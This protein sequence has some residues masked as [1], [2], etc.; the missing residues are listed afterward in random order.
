MDPEKPRRS[1]VVEVDAPPPRKLTPPPINFEMHTPKVNPKL[2]FIACSRRMRKAAAHS[3]AG[4]PGLFALTCGTV[5][6]SFILA[7][8]LLCLLNIASIASIV[9][10]ALYL[11]EC[12]AQPHIPVMLVAIG[13]I[14]VLI[15]IL[16]AFD[17]ITDRRTK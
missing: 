2:K 11:H 12:P 6:C 5:C 15:C 10:G 3:R 16:D 17:R 1:L 14:A 7:I 4:P 13:S 9:V 8:M